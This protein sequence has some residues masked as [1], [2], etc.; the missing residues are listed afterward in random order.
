MTRACSRLSVLLCAAALQAALACAAGL[1]AAAPEPAAAAV[2]LD[3]EP[4]AS[5]SAWCGFSIA[6]RGGGPQVAFFGA[7]FLACARSGEEA[8]V[9]LEIDLKARPA[10]VVADVELRDGGGA[11]V[12][13]AID[14]GRAASAAL[15]P[16]GTR[17]EV[18]AGAIER[19]VVRLATRGTSGEAAVLWRSVRLEAAGG[20]I[21]VAPRPRPAEAG[22]GPPPVLPPLRR[23]VEEA[24]VEWDWR[25][26]DGIGTERRPATYLEA[27]ERTL[28]RGD[29]LLRDAMASRADLESEAAQWR[30]LRQEHV[31]LQQTAGSAQDAPGRAE[32]LWRRVH[33]LRRRIA[34]RHPLART[35]PIL[36]AK[37][38]PGAFSHQLTQCYGRYARP[39]GGLFVLEAPGESMRCRQI[40]PRELPEGSYQHPEVSFEGDRVLFSYCETDRA[41][42][43]GFEGHRGRYYHLFEARID[44]G[45]VR[46]LTDGPFDDFSPK[47]LPD[48]RIV[49]VSTRRRGWHRCGSPGCE[50][51]T[52]AIAEADGSGARPISFH[53]TQEWDP[54]VLDD[55]RVVYT[56]WDYVDRHAVHYEHLWTV[57]ADGTAPA[58][59]YG[60]NT[61]NPVGIWEARQVPGTRLVMATA[62]AHHAMTAGSIV[63]VDAARGVDGEA[64]I[65]RLT[66]D[67]P[68]PESETTVAPG[69]RS[70]VPPASP[71]AATPEAERWPGHCCKSPW[72]LSERLFLA[73]YSFDA[74]IGEPKGNLPNM[75]GIYLADASGTKEL[76]YRDLNIASVYPVPVRP[77]PRPPVL[78]PSTDP[79]AGEQG[80]FSVQDASRGDPPLPEGAVKRLRV[81]QVLPKSTPGI[82]NPPVGLANASPGRQVLGTVPVEADGSAFFAA[83]AGV[84]LSFQALDE[85]GM[86]VQTMRSVVYLQSGETSSCIG[87][88]EQRSSAPPA[89][90]ASM[91]LARP[92][93]AIEP[94]PD[95]SRPLSYPLLVQPVLDR[96]C[97]SCHGAKDPQGGLSLTGEPQGHYTVSYNA[98]APRV[99][100]S[101]WTGGA[102]FRE[103]NSEPVSLP[104]R[105]GARASSLL[106][107]LLAGHYDV[108][109]DPGDLERLATW[110]DANALFYGTFDPAAQACQQ[111]GERIAGPG[112]E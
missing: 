50:N 91:A 10:A 57:R 90:G 93:S 108:A 4:A 84:P 67:A 65:V 38:V 75:F 11:H 76:L 101:Q 31:G 53:E 8:V 14:G 100:F 61:F 80:F 60:N 43:N 23:P 107:L 96:L 42:A 33:R 70:T 18:P 45:G 94:G 82:N 103:A 7:S 74:L 37:Q 12:S 85:R 22:P 30:D 20:A 68:F 77:R 9:S 99:P 104:G 109:L 54:S 86:A 87:C 15:G 40:A 25:L 56:R 58:A 47:H 24:L 64:P 89:R 72:P 62:A 52:L 5:S 92:P 102:D 95:G 71:P 49:F 26:Q 13:I 27:T 110:M 39:G 81:V 19:A 44:G 51:Y 21:G 98:L 48:G 83:P 35:G 106:R 34:L 41:P 63:L 66:P 59:F 32:D 28:R 29:D 55:G 3:G 73:A 105:F 16:A 112:L 88:H 17:L 2:A 1:P 97:V 46:R 111:R 69:W 6:A 79:A 78:A 36:F